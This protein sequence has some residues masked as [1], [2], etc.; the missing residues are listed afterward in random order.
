MKFLAAAF[1]TQGSTR[2][3]AMKGKAIIS[4]ERKIILNVFKHFKTENSS[5]N[6]N[7]V[8]TLTF[9]V[10]TTVKSSN[11]I[12]PNKKKEFNKLDELNLG[13]VRR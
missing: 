9:K 5:L 13:G 6:E 3:T 4:G 2:P 7:A 8:I 11:K 12:Q 1:I 10:P